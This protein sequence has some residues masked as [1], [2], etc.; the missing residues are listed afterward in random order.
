MNLPGVSYPGKPFSPGVSYCAESISPGYHTAHCQ[1][2]WGII[3]RIVNLPEVSYSG[4]SFVK[5]CVEISPGYN[6]PA[7]QSP[8]GIILRRVMSLFWILL[9]GHCN[10]IFYLQFFSSFE[11]VCDTNQRVKKFQF[12][13]DFANCIKFFVK[14]L[15]QHRVNLPGV[16][17]STESIS[18]EYH[19][20][21]AQC[22]S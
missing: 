2:P 1:S 14:K 19:T 13:E 7:S 4:K 20:A 10:D 11:R 17:Y 22:H 3:L 21:H 15:I 8:R 12:W 6:T 5:I 18:P 9:K 16:S